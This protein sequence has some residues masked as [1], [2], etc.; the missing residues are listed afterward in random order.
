MELRS[1]WDDYHE[2][3]VNRYYENFHKRFIKI[4]RHLFSLL[5]ENLM[6]LIIQHHSLKT[7][8]TR[9]I[10]K[11]V[12]FIDKKSHFHQHSLNFVNYIICSS[13]IHRYNEIYL[14]IFFSALDTFN[15]KK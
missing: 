12:I 13:Y 2:Q 11:L 14:T 10:C 4:A 1:L 3:I 9:I 15:F 8:E 5:F 6:R 7:C